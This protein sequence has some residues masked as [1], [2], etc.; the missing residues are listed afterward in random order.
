MLCFD[1]QLY[2]YI[3]SISMLAIFY[4][5]FSKYDHYAVL[6]KYHHFAEMVKI[7]FSKNITR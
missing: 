2:M 5:L 7:L 3:T 4:I 6:Q 1:L